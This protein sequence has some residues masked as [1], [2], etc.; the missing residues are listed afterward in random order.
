[1]G[2]TERGRRLTSRDRWVAAAATVALAALYF[3]LRSR[4]IGYDAVAYS[5]IADTPSF[6]R[7]FHQNH[8]LF[9]PTLFCL[10]RVVRALGYAGSSLTPPAALSALWAGAAS[11]AFYLVLRRIGARPAAAAVAVAGASLSAAW[12]HFAGLAEPVASI[13]FFTVGAL[14]LAAPW[15]PSRRRALAVGCWLGVGTW[16]HT[17][18]ALFIPVAGILVAGGSGGRWGRWA[19]L[20]AA[21][22]V[23]ASVA[24]AVVSQC[25]L[26][27]ESVGD[28]CRWI[29]SYK[30]KHDEYG[31]LA[32]GRLP[33]GLL[34]VLV[35][36]VAPRRELHLGVMYMAPGDAALKLAPAAVLVG[37]ALVTVGVAVPRLWREHRRWLVAAVVWFLGYQLFFTWWESGNPSW[38]AVVTLPIW[39]LFG[40][41]A[42]PRRIFLIPVG[43]VVLAAAGVNCGRLI[44]PSSR[45][46]LNKA[47]NAARAFIA[48]SRPGDRLW[49]PHSAVALWIRH[50]TSDDRPLTKTGR[51]VAPGSYNH[52]ALSLARRGGA[53][54]R[55]GADVYLTDYELD[56]PN[57]G[58]GRRANAA[59]KA[60]FRLLR[61]AEPV[62]LAHFYGRP[63]VLYRCDGAAEL[64]SLRIC[65][66]ERGK[67]EKEFG[68][69]REPGCAER[70]VVDVATKGRY[71]ISFQA[72][73][74]PA[75]GE[76]PAASV[77]ADGKVLATFAVTSE[78][79]W[80]Y[81][82]RATLDAGEHEIEVVLLNGFRD[83]AT[84][85]SR[86][87]YVNRLVIYRNPAE[88]AGAG[89]APGRDESPFPL[90]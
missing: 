26:G 75:G 70:F 84:G 79:W 87:L 54:A 49:V 64:E 2:E 28:F 65:E 62:A 38:W 8:P 77:A 33:E 89:E 29:N 31:I 45:P 90:D 76:W 71:V 48:A 68:V 22:A 10:M 47:E 7:M 13:L 55:A 82:T 20:F 25:V 32:A 27:H 80:F 83:P 46:G 78:Y 23:T 14:F 81:D 6:G 53:D 58:T 37:I 12:W 1:V 42:P 41:A 44:L 43:V 30:I 74:T 11:G 57:L 19:A 17:T 63:R 34:Q 21:Y 24:Y 40:L 59:K 61:N 39:L 4:D 88:N 50:L 9:T 72:S 3:A 51:G 5:T 36:S 60:F 56:N 66:A 15:P 16:F 86:F 67:G 69:L 85:A 52:R 35:A 18:L 73:G